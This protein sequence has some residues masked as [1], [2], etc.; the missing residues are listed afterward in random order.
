M[1]KQRVYGGRWENVGQD[2]GA[3]G[4]SVVRR[5]CD[6]TGPT[7]P[8]FALKRL[9]NSARSE[10]FKA[11][12]ESLRRINH[13]NVIK[14][15]DYA[16]VPETDAEPYWFVM[17]L[18][19]GNLE[20]RKGLYKDNLD[21][22]LFV[23]Q[24][25]AAALAAAHAAGVVHRD[26]KPANI[27]FPRLDH[28]V[29]LSDFGICHIEAD[30]D[31]MTEVG[32]AMGPR[33]FTAP[34]LEGGG[35][36]EF[37]PEADIYSLGKVIYFMLTGGELLAREELHSS[38]ALAHFEKSQRHWLLKNLLARMIVQRDRRIKTAEGVL[39]E[40]RRIDK[41]EETAQALALSPDALAAIDKVA[42]QASTR[43]RI[44]ADN[45]EGQVSQDRMI[46]DVS[47]SV[48]AWVQ[49][50]LEKLAA[51]LANGGA[52]AANVSKAVWRTD[53]Y[54]GIEEQPGEFYREVGGVQ[55]NFRNLVGP[56][57]W[58]WT[59]KFYVCVKTRMQITIGNNV[60]RTR[61][62]EPALALVPYLTEAD[63]NSPGN[64]RT[65]GYLRSEAVLRGD[66]PGLARPKGYVYRRGSEPLVAR[67]FVCT[68]TNLAVKFNASEWPGVL[69]EVK[70]M[71]SEAVKVAIEFASSDSRTVG[72]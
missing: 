51:L 52:Y 34:E 10:R 72:A 60:H 42:E 9:K 13:P 67:T 31:R 8:E 59:L 11:E 3:G 70:A 18:A 23:A 53:R 39:E 65:E 43:A 46:E 64:V 1:A 30:G 21:A 5:V 45:A 2:I 38:Q 15:V 24:Q 20:E 12:I 62:G 48:L 35:P 55:L 56:F 29:W 57:K 49:T 4:Q 63:A 66:A 71:Y 58:E 25:L 6:L 50:E 69:D 68:P 32:E 27:L 17:P 19:Q 36:V 47:G 44:L 40:L 7:G 28:D 14:I 61:P 26:V 33:G 16:K 22:V 54:F 37:G 41:W